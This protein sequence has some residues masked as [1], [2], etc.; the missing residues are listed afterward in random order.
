MVTDIAQILLKW[1]TVYVRSWKQDLSVFYI[2]AV[3]ESERVFT[4][5]ECFSIAKAYFMTASVV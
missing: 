4:F 1:I 5:A 3:S 2:Q